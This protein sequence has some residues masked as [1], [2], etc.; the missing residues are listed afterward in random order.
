MEL[1]TGVL[2]NSMNIFPYSQTKV[3]A[4]LVLSPAI[5]ATEASKFN[6]MLFLINFILVNDPEKNYS[7]FYCSAAIRFPH[8]ETVAFSGEEFI[9]RWKAGL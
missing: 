2:C 7:I 8:F 6:D 3:S 4:S 5:S 9:N 1:T